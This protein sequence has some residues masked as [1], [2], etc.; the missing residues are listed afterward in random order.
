MAWAV[1]NGNTSSV[2]TKSPFGDQQ[3]ATVACIV[4][5]GAVRYW[6][7][8]NVVRVLVLS[9]GGTKGAF[10]IGALN[11]LTRKSGMLWDAVIGVSI[12]ALN[13]AMIAQHKLDRLND[14]WLEIQP[15]DIYKGKINLGACL[16]VALGRNYLL[17]STPLMKLIR[18]EIG[19]DTFH[20]PF[21]TGIVDLE[22]GLHFCYPHTCV[23][24]SREYMLQAILASTAIPVIFPPVRFSRPGPVGL[25]VDGGVR[26]T[27]PISKAIGLGADEIVV[28]N[29]S[30]EYML[31]QRN[32]KG[33]LKIGMRTL[34]IAL[35]ELYVEDIR[36]FTEINHLVKQ[37]EAA[38]VTLTKPGSEDSYKYIKA[39]IV[40]PAMPLG[41]ILDFDP[42]VIRERMRAGY[43][44][45]AEAHT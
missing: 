27:S 25:Y 9:G 40:R 13:G 33:G 32:I 30:P 36:R 35:N 15:S 21:Y 16:K 45:A 31:R 12:G 23:P 44:A 39:M 8:E 1:Q 28:V 6:I 4:G 10:Q 37:A 22:I 11:Y 38:G 17:S 24:R 3:R 43:E 2:G 7:M 42:S 26:N 34:D 18:R 14:I 5:A 29:C 20:V 41:D 19:T